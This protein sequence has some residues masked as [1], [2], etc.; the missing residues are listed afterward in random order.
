MP[1]SRDI[2][3]VADLLIANWQTTQLEESARAALNRYY[4]A[5]IL[6]RVMAYRGML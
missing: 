1:R 2:V 6:R 4:Y 3:I 5:A